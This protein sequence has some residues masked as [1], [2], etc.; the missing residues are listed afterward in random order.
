M[1][2]NRVTGMD[3]IGEVVS[4]FLGITDSKYQYVVDAYERHQYE[5]H[6]QSRT[7]NETWLCSLHFHC[8][9]SRSVL[10]PAL[11]WRWK[12]GRRRL[13]GAG[14]WPKRR[15]R[16]CAQVSAKVLPQALPNRTM[17]SRC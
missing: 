10:V 16:R 7:T 4:D 3:F 15:M 12:S 8:L 2:L 5:V 11:R 14:V 1:V 9:S 6:T 13:P 17:H